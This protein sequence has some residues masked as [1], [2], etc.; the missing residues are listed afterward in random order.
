MGLGLIADHLDCGTVWGHSGRGFGYGNTPY[1]R[2]ETGRLAV[3]MLNGS[4][5]YRVH[6]EEPAEAPPR[7]SPE[8]RASVYC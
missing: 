4:Y 1:L 6:S 3:L 8:L 5:G 2:L 7:F